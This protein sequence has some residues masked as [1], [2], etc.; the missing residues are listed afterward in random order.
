MYPTCAHAE[1]EVS[2]LCF[3]SMSSVE[4]FPLYL[5]DSALMQLI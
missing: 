4:L 2:Y 5:L 3:C 1:I